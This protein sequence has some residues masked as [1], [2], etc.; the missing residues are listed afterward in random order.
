MTQKLDTKIQH[1]LVKVFGNYI[2]HQSQ[3]IDIK[4][5]TL[6]TFSVFV[7]FSIIFCL[8][9]HIFQILS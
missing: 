1:T 4:G 5:H 7:T 9:E 3:I 2:I 8:N 6:A